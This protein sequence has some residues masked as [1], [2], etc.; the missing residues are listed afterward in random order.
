MSSDCSVVYDFLGLSDFL[1][2]VDLVLFKFEEDFSFVQF[3]QIAV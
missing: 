3:V 1:S 2:H